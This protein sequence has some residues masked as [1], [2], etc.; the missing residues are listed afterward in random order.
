MKKIIAS[1]LFLASA[2]NMAWGQT[3]SD[4]VVMRING[5]DVTRS[6][7]EY[8]Y[9]KNNAAGVTDKKTL[10]EYVDL[11]VNYKLKVEAALD[12]RMDTLSSFQKEFRQYRD[13]QIRPLLVKQEQVDQAVYDYYVQMK[14]NIGPQGLVLPAHVFVKVSQKATDEEQKAAKQRIDSI[15][16]ELKVGA[17]FSEIAQA[18]SDD[19]STGMRGGELGWISPKQ[20]LKEF[21]DVA[22]SLQKGEMSEPFRSTVGYHIVLMKDRKQVEPF[23]ELKPRIAQFMEQRGLKDQLAMQ[24]VDSLSKV[25]E[26][27][28]TVDLVMDNEAERLS[29]LDTDLKYLIKEYHD[30]LLLYEV[31]STQIWNKAATDT[32]GLQRYFKKNKK[33]YAY[34]VPHFRGVFFQCRQAEDVKQV[35]SLL[36][37]CPESQWIKELRKT[38]NNDSVPRV[39][40]EKKIFKKGDNKLVDVLAFKEKKE[41]VADE[42]YPY[43]EVYGRVMKKM[44][45]DWTDVRSEVVSDYQNQKE[46]EFIADLRNKYKVEIIEEVLNTVNKH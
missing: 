18:C 36:K 24:T 25:S 40:V 29:A 11:F 43:A 20:T 9:N 37:S 42:V 32:L 19:K 15:Y 28:L 31:C 17:D 35:K 44:P 46:E 22:Y 1:F 38:F 34:D 30:G 4:P 41:W 8:N 2:W 10:A 16:K 27:T 45:V 14:N 39:R 3:D 12:A 5:K 13:Q 23:E 26:G 21:E 33:K 7:F 6:E